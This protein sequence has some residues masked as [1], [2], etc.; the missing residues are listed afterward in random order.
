V[1]WWHN[2]ILID[3]STVLNVKNV[4]YKLLSPV[5]TTSGVSGSIPY[6]RHLHL[7]VLHPLFDIMANF[8][9]IF[10]TFI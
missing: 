5:S 8:A 10:E 4:G 6:G 1:C 9:A 7:W 3:W 2:P